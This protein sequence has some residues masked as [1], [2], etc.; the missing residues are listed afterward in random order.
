MEHRILVTRHVYPDAIERLR[1]IGDVDWNDGR[2]G[3][4]PA[5]LQ[6][7][8]HGATALVCQLTDPIGAEVMDA[9]PRLRVIANVAVGYDNIDVAAAKERGIVVTNTPGVL[10]D[11][12]ADFTWALMMAT[13]RRI[14]DAD[15]YLR[16]GH[17]RQWEID[18]LCG[19]DVFGRTL[20]I[21][22][23][24]RIGQAVA[25]R[26]RG[27]DMRVLYASRTRL[28]A[29][30][31]RETNATWAPL[32]DL[33]TESDVVSL[34]CPLTPQT[35]GLIDADALARMKSTAILVNTARGAVVDEAALTDALRDRRIAGA[36]LDVFVNEPRVHPGLL[37]ARTAVLC[38][39]VASAAVETR[40][41]MCVMAAENVA[42]VLR[43]D[44]APNP[45]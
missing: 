1:E 41:R 28:D 12:T 14:V 44:V 40:T 43:G 18:L 7:R 13:A 27:F 6:E 9:A 31:E 5:A 22:G 21:V 42:A 38:P 24:G 39:H 10:T 29:E 32:D 33:L 35:H 25:R 37:D 45:I 20:G 3:L 15:R 19:H 36:G 30:R 2:N 26:A 16:D 4:A 11:S 17:W 8:I 23:M 34:H